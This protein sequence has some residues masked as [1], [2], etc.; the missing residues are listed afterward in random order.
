MNEAIARAC[1]EARKSAETFRL[2]AAVL[3][4]NAVVAAGR[5]RNLNSCGLASI[6]AEMDAVF[7]CGVPLKRVHLVVVRVLR[8]GCT[9]ALS[10]PCESCRRAL[11]RLGVRKVTYSTGD[12]RRPFET[13]SAA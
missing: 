11:G 6:H 10:K 5:N 9:T 1:V 7:K 12:P 8:D 3:C 2:G 13:V 4:R